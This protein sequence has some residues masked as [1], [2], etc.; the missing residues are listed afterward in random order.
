MPHSN[1][2]R[3][4]ASG[5]GSIRKKTITNNGK[6]Y[7]YW[8]AR[9]TSGFDPGTGKQRQHSI[10]GKTQKEVAQKL[11]QATADID[12]HTY[13][14]PS[15]IRLAAWLD[16]WQNSY[17]GGVKPRTVE[18]YDTLI[19]IHIKPALG[20][21]YLTSLNTQMIQNFYND[22]SKK[23]SAKTVKNVHCVIH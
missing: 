6:T 14:E 7:T 10:T 5:S 9:Y 11:R 18:I 21:T 20:A 1:Q 15:K 23:L 17:L 22:V 8:E 3:K 12:C 16:I 2:N 19:R 13:V 4:N